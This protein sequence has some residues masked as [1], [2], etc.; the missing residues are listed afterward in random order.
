MSVIVFN[1]EGED[2]EDLTHERFEM[3][4]DGF[5]YIYDSEGCLE[6]F[7]PSAPYVVRAAGEV[8]PKGYARTDEG[9]FE[10]VFD[11]ATGQ[12]GY[13]RVTVDGDIYSS[14]SRDPAQSY[15][16]RQRKISDDACDLINRH[17]KRTHGGRV[18]WES[19]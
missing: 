1:T 14:Y 7:M 4:Q 12:I 6:I 10:T 11:F 19:D 9:Y 5:R 15:Y 17:I 16:E 2:I 8:N 3:R 13:T 18:S